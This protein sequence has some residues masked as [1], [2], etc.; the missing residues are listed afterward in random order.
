[1]NILILIVGI[2]MLIAGA[3]IFVNSSVNIAK[4]L[5]VPTV[6]IALTIIAIG[7]SAPET[8]I[9]ITAS[10]KG[11]SDLSMSNII[12]SN[13]F[14]LLFIVGVAALIKPIKVK[15]KEVGIESWLMVC[16]TVTLF[17][18]MIAT[19]VLN[20][21][22]IPR[23]VGIIMVV[24]FVVYLLMLIRHAL[25]G[26]RSHEHITH[27][28]SVDIPHEK[29]KPLWLASLGVIF[30][31]GIIIY[32]GELTVSHAEAIA[33]QFNVPSRIIGLTII[34]AGTSLPE[35]IIVLIACKKRDS[36]MALG[37]IIGTNIYNLLFILGVA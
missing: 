36:G 16:S 4:K 17:L 27:H 15:M 23:A 7:T 32:G 26:N 20:G 22:R 19:P 8:V 24:T 25:R 2:G 35:L 28:S 5:K 11:H 21:E 33:Q 29:T 1:M 13:Y 30:G 14:N 3:E 18:I 31:L 9:S 6:V 10:L 37:T 34:G 12:G